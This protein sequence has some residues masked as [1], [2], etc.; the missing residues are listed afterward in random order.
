MSDINTDLNI[1][2]CR[3]CNL[4]FKTGINC[5][6]FS[7]IDQVAS[8]VDSGISGPCTPSTI[9]EDQTMSTFWQSPAAKLG[10]DELEKECTG[11]LHIILSAWTDGGVAFKGQSRSPSLWP[12]IGRNMNIV[13]DQ[14]NKH[15][16][17]LAL[18]EGA[19]SNMDMFLSPLFQE[20][21]LAKNGWLTPGGKRVNAGIGF[22]SGDG[23]ALSA[24]LGCQGHNGL[25]GCYRCYTQSQSVPFGS[26]HYFAHN[27]DHHLDLRSPSECAKDC[28][29]FQ[30]PFRGTTGRPGLTDVILGG[31]PYKASIHDG[32][33]SIKNFGVLLFGLILG[34]NVPQK[35]KL[36]ELTKQD[37][38]VDNEAVVA[39]HAAAKKKARE[40]QKAA[41][42]KEKQLA[43]ENAQRLQ[44]W[45]KDCNAHAR[46]ILPK[47]AQA[48]AR[49]RWKLTGA[50]KTHINADSSPYDYYKSFSI[51]DWMKFL[52]FFAFLHEGLFEDDG[53]FLFLVGLC[54][55]FVRLCR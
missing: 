34:N 26:G 31:D 3:I 4:P 42:V 20:L 40:A 32:A 27:P 52:P 30:L 1:A 9:R 13:A 38:P 53:L 12:V 33:H 49:A 24:V 41:S 25:Y 14:R 11:A 22:F 35:P 23:P 10:I 21:Q 2:K 19:P 16:M 18:S 43:K 17:L 28:N 46:W 37:E 8:H 15:L 6:Y 55:A 51:S 50:P 5:W 47:N 45:T 36:R 39:N 48:I 29:Q 44:Q 7:V 54:N